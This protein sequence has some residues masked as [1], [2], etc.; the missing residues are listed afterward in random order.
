[1]ESFDDLAGLSLGVDEWSELSI[2]DLTRMV[3]RL[4]AHPVEM[5][6]L[7][8]RCAEHGRAR[9]LVALA[10]DPSTLGESLGHAVQLFGVLAPQEPAE[11]RAYLDVVSK[12]MRVTALQLLLDQCPED[13]PADVAGAWACEVTGPT[14]GERLPVGRLD[15]GRLEA[16]LQAMDQHGVLPVPQPMPV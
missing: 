8:T 15:R 3:S 4:H 13:V 10:N 1:M 9:M 11:R 5:S 6:R 2:D 12:L 16:L 14:Q 7:S